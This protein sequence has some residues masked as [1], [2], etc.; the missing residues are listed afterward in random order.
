MKGRV[1]FH[2]R[3]KPGRE[4]DFLQAYQ[5][6][7]HL[8]AEGVKGHIL[9]QICQSIADPLDW[10]I[11]SEWEDIADFLEWERDPAHTALVKPMRECW[12]EAKSHKYV[13]RLETGH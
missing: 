10:L 11:T 3:L 1:V 13:V 12:D 4:D 9:D 2:I 7:R 6:V 8:V 5:G